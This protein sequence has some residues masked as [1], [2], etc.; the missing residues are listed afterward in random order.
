MKLALIY[1][2]LDYSKVSNKHADE[3][4]VL[5]ENLPKIK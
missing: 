3:I 2:K 4:S 5:V 1:D